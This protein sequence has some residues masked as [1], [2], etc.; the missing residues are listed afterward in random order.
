MKMNQSF[1]LS[2]FKIV[3]FSVCNVSASVGCSNM[4][5]ESHPSFLRGI[6]VPEPHMPVPCGYKVAVVLRERYSKHTAGHLVGCNNSPLLRAKKRFQSII[7]CKPDSQADF[8]L[9]GSLWS[10]HCSLL[11]EHQMSVE[12]QLLH[13]EHAT[14]PSKIQHESCNRSLMCPSSVVRNI[15][16]TTS[17]HMIDWETHIYHLGNLELY[18]YR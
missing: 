3:I 9:T 12:V 17:E 7:S 10:V 4:C 8:W 18:N 6:K 16:I 5:Q 14:V 11:T 2:L 15:I 1:F 13:S